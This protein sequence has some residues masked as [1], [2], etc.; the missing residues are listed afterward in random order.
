M[1]STNANNYPATQ[2][3][4]EAYNEASNDFYSSLSPEGMQV[5]KT[6]MALVAMKAHAKDV[7]KIEGVRKGTTI[8]TFDEQMVLSCSS[9]PGAHI[10]KEGLI[11]LGPVGEVAVGAWEKAHENDERGTVLKI[12]DKASRDIEL[13]II[14]HW[15]EE[16]EKCIALY[17][18]QAAQ[19]EASQ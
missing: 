8:K 17:E 3:A 12:Q 7:G 18:A 13:E 2:A 14:A 9:A 10:S 11:E 6:V 15:T 19:Q 4:L 1:D 5:L 16:R